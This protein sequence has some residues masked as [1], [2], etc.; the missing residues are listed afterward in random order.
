MVVKRYVRVFFVGLFFL[1]SSTAAFAEERAA[2][3]SIGSN[4]SGSV[5]ITVATVLQVIGHAIGSGLVNKFI[6]LV[7]NENAIPIEGGGTACI[8]SG[9][10]FPANPPFTEDKFTQLLEQLRSIQP[11]PGVFL[12]VELTEN[13]NV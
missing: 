9:F 8:A 2:N 7:P 1:I 4:G 10:D 5:S 11:E 6:V 12:N 13:C 3:I